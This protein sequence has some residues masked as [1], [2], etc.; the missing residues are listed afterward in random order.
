M[1]V[2]CSYLLLPGWKGKGLRW[3][4]VQRGMCLDFDTQSAISGASK[5]NRERERERER[6]VGRERG[7]R[8]T[9]G[10]RCNERYLRGTLEALEG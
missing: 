6:E 10:T 3:Y 8:Y 4:N 2:G 7:G 5:Y 1:Y 9:K